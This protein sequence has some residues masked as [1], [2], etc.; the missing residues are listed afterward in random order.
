[1]QKQKPPE[2]PDICKEVDEDERKRAP[3]FPMKINVFL[4]KFFYNDSASIN[5]S[6]R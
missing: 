3:K 5:E 1:M 6:S 2:Q 4:Y